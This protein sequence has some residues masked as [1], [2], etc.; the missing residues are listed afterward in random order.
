MTRLR[1]SV[2]ACP[3]MQ[4]ELEMLAAESGTVVA[5]RHLEMGLHERAGSA[6]H[7]ALQAAIDEAG[8]CD[9]VA[10]GYGLCNRGVAG[11]VARGSA[12]GDPAGA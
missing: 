12:C 8:D 11:L 3:S 10:L 1:L 9:A 4:P 7:Q 6:L 5:F 2:I